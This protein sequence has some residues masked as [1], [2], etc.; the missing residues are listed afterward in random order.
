[1]TQPVPEPDQREFGVRV[2]QARIAA[3]LTLDQLAERS[4]VSRRMLIEIEQ[5][6]ANPSNRIVHAIAHATGA[7]PGD[8]ANALCT[9]HPL[10]NP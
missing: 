7:N 1:M 9:H 5:G 3:H 10:P 2:A 8:L 6:R 4:A